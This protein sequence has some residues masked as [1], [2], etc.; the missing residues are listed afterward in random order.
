MSVAFLE[1]FPGCAELEGLCGG[2]GSAVVK[3]AV[4]NREAM[5]LSVEASFS[6][7]PAPAELDTLER[8]LCEQYG[9]QSARI[10]ADH[11]A[12]GKK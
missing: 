10:R 2:L 12:E 11:P 1:I 3:S 9:L 7:R 8:R 4:V 6:R 5:S